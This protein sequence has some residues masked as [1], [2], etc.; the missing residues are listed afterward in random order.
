MLLNEKVVIPIVVHILHGGEPMGTGRNISDAQIQSQID[1]LNEDFRRT[2]SDQNN[3]PAVFRN[4]GADANVEFKLACIDPNGNPTNGINRLLVSSPFRLSRFYGGGADENTTGIK[5]TAKGGKDAWN[6]NKYLNIWVCELEEGIGNILYGYSQYP[7]EFASKSLTDGIVMNYNIFGRSVYPSP[8]NKGHTLA[9]E[10]GHWL[11]L[12]HIWGVTACGDDFVADT[13]TQYGPSN[14]YTCPTFPKLSCNNGP[15]GDMFSNFMDYTG[16][17]CK[18]MFT[19]GQVARMRAFL[20]TGDRANTEYMVLGGNIPTATSAT[21]FLY[22]ND[23]NRLRDFNVNNGGILQVNGFGNSK[24]GTGA[25]LNGAA[26]TVNQDCESTVNIQSGGQFVIGEATRVGIV[27]IRS[28][29]IVN[30]NSGSTL[31]IANSS[32]LQI[33]SGGKLVINAG[34]NINLIDNDSRIQ[35]QSG[36]ELTINGQF[37]FSGSGYLSFD[38]DNILTLNSNLILRGSSKTNR[39]ISIANGASIIINGRKL[40]LENGLIRREAGVIPTQHIKLINGSSI[41]ATDATFEDNSTYGDRAFVY[42]E[43]PTDLANDPNNFD[44]G[45][46]NC[47]FSG[48]SR[49]VQLKTL[50]DAGLNQY[51]WLNVSVKFLSCTFNN[52]TALESNRNR[53]AAFHYCTLNTSSI[54]IGNAY[55]LDLVGTTLRGNSLPAGITSKGVVHTELNDNSTIDNYQIGIVANEGFN[56]NVTMRTASKI[57][58]CYQAVNMSGGVNNYLGYDWGAMNMDCAGL[59]DN[60]YGI[61]GIDIAFN[62]YGRS[63][64]NSIVIHEIS[65]EIRSIF[66][67]WKYVDVKFQYRNNTTDVWFID[68]YWSFNTVNGS[69][70]SPAFFR[71]TKQYPQFGPWNGTVHTDDPISYFTVFINFFDP[72][73]NP[74]GGLTTRGEK[75]D[76]F[77]AKAVIEIDGALYNT[78]IQHD[79][80]MKFA[81][82]RN[83]DK[84]V[85]LFKP[86]AKISQKDYEKAK[87]EVRH[88]VD[89]ARVWTPY[90]GLN[91]REAGNSGWIPEA[92]VGMVEKKDGS[93]LIKPNPTDADL[94]IQLADGGKYEV[95]VFDALGKLILTVNTEGSNHINT[96]NWQNGIYFV[97]VT[98][99]SN[100][101]IRNNK[102]VVQH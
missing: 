93:F 68:S 8:F 17:N 65:P 77:I 61:T 85:D 27:N 94:E 54:I 22:G 18:N 43:N 91:S 90:K 69:I 64:S 50:S 75:K 14:S 10:V 47:A 79:A 29:G 26:V 96:S 97:K 13:P 62:M 76:P 24:F 45:F 72:R 20:F 82:A 34:A 81:T 25:A 67:D 21:R 57:Q 7:W 37:N 87:P 102:V 55:W 11:G 63:W 3:A 86:L 30:L 51:D 32:L 95:S 9:H 58:N 31:K 71:F 83:F 46:T 60:V 101:E 84:A 19:N 66:P 5:F 12:F 42:A 23:F 56:H 70:G 74:C 36:G 38:Q 48:G 44:Y 52:C 33:Q 15:N 6:T 40:T 41:Q 49:A 78:K 1:V 88:F 59:V 2:N 100:N 4:L 39:M 99:K 89:I 80:A 53:I 28:G 98:D 35:I 16:D 73:I 92:F